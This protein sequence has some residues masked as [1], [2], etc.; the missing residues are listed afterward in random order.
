M[1]AT[2]TILKDKEIG[3]KIY[4]KGLRQAKQLL[5]EIFS[6][7]FD[8]LENFKHYKE[9]S[10]AYSFEAVFDFNNREVRASFQFYPEDNDMLSEVL[11]IWTDSVEIKKPIFIFSNEYKER[12]SQLMSFVEKN[13][14]VNFTPL[15][16]EEIDEQILY[17]KDNDDVWETEIHKEDKG[18]IKI[19]YDS[20]NQPGAISLHQHIHHR[21]VLE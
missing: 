11:D 10:D 16:P 6:V 1:K 21:I 20:I 15:D 18:T 17:V 2:K 7:N 19:I 14:D 12:I 4:E 5:N 13:Y 9:D 3:K 8:S